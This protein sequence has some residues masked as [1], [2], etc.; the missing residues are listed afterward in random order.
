MDFILYLLCSWFQLVDS[1]TLVYLV[2]VHVAGEIKHVVL[3]GTVIGFV[4]EVFYDE[5]L[6]FGTWS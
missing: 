3:V 4:V 1:H 2:M 5:L 6:C